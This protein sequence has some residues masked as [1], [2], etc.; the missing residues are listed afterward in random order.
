MVYSWQSD[1][2]T[3]E[4]NADL[5][6]IELIDR[7]DIKEIILNK[8]LFNNN[9][10]IPIVHLRSEVNLDRLMRAMV[11]NIRAEIYGKQLRHEEIKYPL[12]WWDALKERWY[13]KWLLRK[14]PAKYKTIVLDIKE[15]YPEIS[16]PDRNPIIHLLRKDSVNKKY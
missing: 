13:P 14:Y 6:N 16:A 4:D 11:V 7:N 9:A 3:S 8:I 1:D 2:W 12:T 10:M 5:D 15:L